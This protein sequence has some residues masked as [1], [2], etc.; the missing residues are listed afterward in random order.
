MPVEDKLTIMIR[1]YGSGMDR[2]TIEN[3]FVPFYTKKTTGTG[4]G[5]PIAQKIVEGHKGK[6][7]ISSK[8]GEGTEIM[9]EI[10]RPK[11]RGP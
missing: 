10:P 8:P 7:D 5:M 4:L 11:K 6:I 3:I 1:D 2:E 9:I